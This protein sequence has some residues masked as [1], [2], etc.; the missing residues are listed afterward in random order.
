MEENNFI[1]K[2]GKQMNDTIL[3]IK[4]IKSLLLMGLFSTTIGLMAIFAL[5]YMGFDYIQIVI[6]LPFIAMIAF[7]IGSIMYYKITGVES[8]YN[9][10]KPY[11]RRDMYGIAIWIFIFIIICL[12]FYFY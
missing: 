6:T 2:E 9:N 11:L 5:L 10:P 3:S 8:S 4:K 1:Q 7:L 12:V